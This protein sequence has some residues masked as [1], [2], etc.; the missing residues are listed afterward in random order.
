MTFPDRFDSAETVGH[1]VTVGTSEHPRF[2]GKPAVNIR[3]Q[4]Y[5]AGGGI[6]TIYSVAVLDDLIAQ[7]TRARREMVESEPARAEALLAIAEREPYVFAR[8]LL[9]GQRR[10]VQIS[11]PYSTE[12]GYRLD[13]NGV[14]PVCYLTLD[15]AKALAYEAFGVTEWRRIASDTTPDVI[16]QPLDGDCEPWQ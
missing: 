12:E 6:E 8:R 16:Y 5:G 15:G 14:R 10:R 11:A 3:Q 4:L 13:L 7:L 1:V 2:E 9:N